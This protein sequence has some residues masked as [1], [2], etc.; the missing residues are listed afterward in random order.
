MLNFLFTLALALPQQPPPA[1]P[2]TQASTAQEPIPDPLQKELLALAG[3]FNTARHAYDQRLDELRKA[4]ESDPSALPPHPSIAFWPRVEELAQ[5]GSI[6]ARLWLALQFTAAHP[7]LE[8]AARDEAWRTRVLA[9]V[10]ACSNSTLERDLV[11]AFTSL[12]LDAPPALVDEALLDFVK[13]TKQRELAAEALYRGSLARPRGSKGLAS[14]QAAEFEKRLQQDFADSAA[15]RAARGEP[16]VGLAVGKLAPDFVA[17]DADGVA[18]KLSDY[19]GK[20]VVLDFW[21]FW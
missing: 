12:Y 20:V 21:G 16:E 5:R 1:A 9:A 6:G 11:R 7:G 3:E 10:E 8:G 14:I 13:R 4:G 19:R 17:K 18:F 2:A 15:A